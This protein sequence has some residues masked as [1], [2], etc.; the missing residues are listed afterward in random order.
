[1]K[2]NKVNQDNLVKSVLKEYNVKT[3]EDFYE[4]I[5]KTWNI[6]K[7]SCGREIDLTV[8]KF[9]DGDPVCNFCK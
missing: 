3:E 5:N 9:R 6:T 4:L 1:M 2:T 7:C 8:C